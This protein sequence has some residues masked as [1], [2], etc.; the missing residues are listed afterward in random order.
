MTNDLPSFIQTETLAGGGRKEICQ[1]KQLHGHR[2]RSNGKVHIS[3][4]KVSWLN[5]LTSACLDPFC[6]CE[7]SLISVGLCTL[8][9]PHVKRWLMD[10]G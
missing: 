7:M 6:L 4:E 5:V 10:E 2:G 9:D 8:L 1:S 3:G